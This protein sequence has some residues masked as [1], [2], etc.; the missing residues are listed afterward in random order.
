MQPEIL[1]SG[2]S[3]IIEAIKKSR[4][5][6][7]RMNSYAI[8]RIAETLRALVHDACDIRQAPSVL[9]WPSALP[10]FYYQIDQ[11]EMVGSVPK[12]NKEYIRNIT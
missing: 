11:N 1:S 9:L 10:I 3:E 12:F 2:L 6:F 5:I 8:Y 7:Q 4:S